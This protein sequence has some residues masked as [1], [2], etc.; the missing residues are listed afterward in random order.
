MVEL[1]AISYRSHLTC[2]WAGLANRDASMVVRACETGVVLVCCGKSTPVPPSIGGEWGDPG[3]VVRAG[4][5]ISVSTTPR[6][7]LLLCAPEQCPAF[8][9]ELLAAAETSAIFVGD[10]SAQ[11]VHLD[12]AGPAA[13]AT[14]QQGTGVDLRQLKAAAA[15]ATRVGGVHAILFRTSDESLQLILDRADAPRLFAWLCRAGAAGGAAIP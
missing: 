4:G 11:F 5:L 6:Q 7:W 3:M 12:L 8:A 15:V 14:M 9:S 1:A 13:Y 2:D 10:R